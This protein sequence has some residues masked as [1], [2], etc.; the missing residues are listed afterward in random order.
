MTYVLPSL[1]RG[2]L[3]GAIPSRRAEAAESVIGGSSRNGKSTVFDEA[4]RKIGIELIKRIASGDES[5]LSEFYDRFAVTLY[6][7]AMKIM[8]EARDAEDALQEGLVYI[9]RK[10]AVY[11]PRLSSPY[12][13]AVM[14]VRNK[15][16]DRLRSRLRVERIV[17]RATAE[18]ANRCDVDELS[19]AE[20]ELREQRIAVR[21]I[22][23]QLTVEQR[24]ALELAFFSGLTHEEIASHL[25][26]PLG[27]IKARIR[28]GLLRLREVLAGTP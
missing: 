19:A 8:K 11:D 23:S 9:W 21:S 22:L 27:T 2:D 4:E 12:S 28:R 14:I 25:E 7:V 6:S 3:Q 5:A 16:I 24:Q 15:C 10:A 26:T 18:F 1:R 17:E 20:P 13:W